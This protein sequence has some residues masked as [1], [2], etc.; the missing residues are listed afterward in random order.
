[1]WRAS[2]LRR[3]DVIKLD[4]DQ[5]KALP[6]DLAVDNRFY[7]S[8]RA[9]CGPS[10]APPEYIMK[11]KSADE[12]PRGDLSND[13]SRGD[14]ASRPRASKPAT[15]R[16]VVAEL[17]ESQRRFQS[18]LDNVELIAMTLDLESK[19]TFANDFLLS[20][21]GW[22]R[23]ELLGKDWFA[24]FVPPEERLLPAVF[25]ALIEDESHARHYENEILT[26]SGERRMIRWNNSVLRDVSGQVNG[27]VSIGEDLTER[28][29]QTRQI[30]RLSRARQILASINQLVTRVSDRRTLFEDVCR[31]VF[32]EGRFLMA[33]IGLK[34][35][36]GRLSISAVRGRDEGYTQ[37]VLDSLNDNTRGPALSLL[38]SGNAVICNDIEVDALMAPW[39][40]AALDRGFRSLGCFP[41]RESGETVG[42]L[43]LYSGEKGAFD[44]EECRLLEEACA[45]I[46]HALNFIARD[47]R[48]GY[49]QSYDPITRLM[50]RNRFKERLTDALLLARQ[51]N[52][53]LAVLKIDIARFKIVNDTLGHAGSDEVLRLLA[54]RLAVFAG[55][56]QQVG[57]A[58]GDR[59]AILMEDIPDPAELR[60]HLE[61]DLWPRLSLPFVVAGHEIRSGI[62]VGIA[63]FPDDGDDADALLANSEA[64]LRFA[65][66]STEREVFFRREMRPDPGKLSLE[67][68]LRRAL[69]LKEFVLHYQPKIDL[70][71][72]VVC[73]AEALL[74][75]E[76][77]EMGLVPPGRFVPLLEETGLIVDVGRW[78][79]QQAIADH[80]RWR[81]QGLRVGKIAVNVSPLQL[82]QPDFVEM[83]ESVLVGQGLPGFQIEVTESML[84]GDA[85]R[86]IGNLERIRSL[87][88]DIAIDDFGT[89]Y[90]SL[91]YLVKLP[92]S[93]LKIDRSFVVAMST[94][95]GTLVIV[96]TIIALAHSLKM[97]VVAEGVDSKEQL[98]ILREMRCDQVQGFLFSKGLP[99]SEFEELLRS[100]RRL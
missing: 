49:L 45:D 98:E 95:P 25:R 27:T 30:Q 17:H 79:M 47:D 37:G 62:R 77:P 80:V 11:S 58:D 34:D 3:D 9:F 8:R 59:F 46:S 88:V 22:T 68:Q 61:H 6:I 53:R 13:A 54:D 84:M 31:I 82:R 48:L 16:Q 93:T 21:T 40:E 96:S 69:E 76:S 72:D 43:C 51:R 99:T 71:Q 12:S 39:R 55:S 89:G 83:L 94:D 36:E 65:K 10:E 24:T 33:W 85:D 81:E 23:E 91:A 18:I 44:T 97:T 2:P 20:L 75:W 66:I 86:M 50:N 26:R 19:I 38:E 7:P 29:A 57:R 28:L 56:H 70:A 60:A 92:V 78:V 67:G 5:E 63:Q 74:R 35:S 32:E 87:G 15:L 73:G 42:S 100:G 14:R 52:R 41:L 1:L 4:R 90:S 64:A